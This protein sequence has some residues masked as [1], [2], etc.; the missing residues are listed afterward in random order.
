VV[1]HRYARDDDSPYK[2]WFFLGAAL[3]MYVNWQLST[4]V[5]VLFGQAVPDVAAWGLDFAMI[6]TFIGIAVPMMRTRP[7]VASAVVAAVVALATWHLPY[8]L[9]LL[10]AALAGIVVGV[11]LERRAERMASQE[12]RS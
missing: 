7:Q 9:G 12:V 11:W 3:T 2:H 5:G 10:A 1:Q 8:K 6:A 4:L